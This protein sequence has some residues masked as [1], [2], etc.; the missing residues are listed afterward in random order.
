MSFQTLKK[1]LMN[2]MI[3][4]FFVNQ[5]ELMHMAMYFI[6]FTLMFYINY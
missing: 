2:Y 4:L 3:T 1:V 6:H 5:K